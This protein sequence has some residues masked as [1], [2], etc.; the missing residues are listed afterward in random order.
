MIFTDLLPYQR[1]ELTENI[2]F[3][4]MSDGVGRQNIEKCLNILGVTGL[5]PPPGGAHAAQ[6]VTLVIC[7]Q[8]N[9]SRS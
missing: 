5:R 4:L 2:P 7:F 8:N 3:K 6:I 1:K 9:F